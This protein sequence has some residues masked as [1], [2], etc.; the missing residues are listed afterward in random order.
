M[1]FRSTILSRSQMRQGWFSF[2]F[3]KATTSA[4]FYACGT[5]TNVAPT[6][7][8]NVGGLEGV[9]HFNLYINVDSFTSY[10]L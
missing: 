4:N 5:P 2:V 3:V 10:N 7:E 6:L 8:H 1:L 9:L